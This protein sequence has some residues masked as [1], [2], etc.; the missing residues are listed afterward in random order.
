MKFPFSKR[1]YEELNLISEEYLPIYADA[2]DIFLRGFS[3]ITRY[4]KLNESQEE[5]RIEQVTY[6]ENGL[7]KERNYW[8][9]NGF[10]WREDKFT[11]RER[12]L[13]IKSKSSKTLW[14]FNEGGF[15]SEAVYG[16]ESGY[17]EKIVFEYDDFH[18]PIQIND[19]IQIDWN[20][21]VPIESRNIKN[22]SILTK[23]TERNSKLSKILY[24]SAAN[25]ISAKEPR[26][27]TYDE[28]ERL[29]L[30]ENKYWRTEISYFSYGMMSGKRVKKFCN[31]K[32]ISQYYEEERLID[33]DLIE[34]KSEYQ[35][36]EHGEKQS[37]R[38]VKKIKT[39]ANKG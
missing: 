12:N 33:K 14:K 38:T 34:M 7:I 2:K 31:Q 21:G 23:I 36:I 32:Q 25:P 30:D 18:N 35:E 29:I 17:E 6:D 15:L 8:D 20:N 11:L 1:D 5:Y 24:P 10:L 3:E 39:A 26:F 4:V 9:K 28:N 19:D 16:F 37:Y 22:G 13:L 27:C